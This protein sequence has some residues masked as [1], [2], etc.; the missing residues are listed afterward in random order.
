MPDVMWL[1]WISPSAPFDGATCSFKGRA[2]SLLQNEWGLGG[3]SVLVLHVEVD[4]SGFP[5]FAGFS[6]ECGD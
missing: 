4:F 1:A 2:N 6:E 5:F 3:W